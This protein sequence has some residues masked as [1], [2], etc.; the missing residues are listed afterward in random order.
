M[1]PLGHLAG[2]GSAVVGALSTFVAVSIALVIGWLYNDTALPLISSFM[3]TS[4]VA[5]MLALR[6]ER[7]RTSVAEVTE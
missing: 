6:V 1:E 7:Q 2:M 4:F 5:W 3:V